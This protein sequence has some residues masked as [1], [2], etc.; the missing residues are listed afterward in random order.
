MLNFLLVYA[1]IA[2]WLTLKSADLTLGK[3]ED[4]QI[5]MSVRNIILVITERVHYYNMFSL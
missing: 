1:A 5:G 3:N 2:A 4:I